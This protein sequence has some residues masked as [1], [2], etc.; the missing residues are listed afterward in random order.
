MPDHNIA[1]QRKQITEFTR[2]TLCKGEKWYILS[3]SW[4]EKWKRYVNYTSTEDDV[5]EGIEDPPGRLDNSDLLANGKLRDSLLEDHDF[6]FVPKTVW[7]AFTEWFGCKHDDSSI[8][9]RIATA[10]GKRLPT[11][12]LKR[13]TFRF[14]NKENDN[15][16]VEQTFSKQDTIADLQNYLHEHL[17]CSADK[18]CLLYTQLSDGKLEQLTDGSIAIDGAS[19]LHEKELYF[20]VVRVL[21]PSKPAA[22]LP[23][24]NFPLTRSSNVGG[25]NIRSGACGLHNLGNTC[26]MNSAIQCIAS[27]QPLTDFF[28]SADWTSEVNVTNPLGARGQIAKAY[29]SLLEQMFRGGDMVVSPRLFKAEVSKYAPQFMGYVQ[30]DAQE[31]MMFLLDG[32]HED[33]NRILNKPYFE[34]KDH[35]GRSD[36]DVAAESWDHFKRRNH[37]IV[38]DHFY[39][40]LKSKVTCREC[41]K[42]SLTFDPY[43]LLSLP[44]PQEELRV[45]HIWPWDASQTPNSVLLRIE[46][47]LLMN[48]QE[49]SLKEKLPPQSGNNYYIETVNSSFLRTYD[50]K[51]ATGCYRPHLFA[52]E[53]QPGLRIMVDFY[54]STGGI[55]NFDLPLYVSVPFSGKSVIISQEKLLMLV[56]DRLRALGCSLSEVAQPEMNGF[57]LADVNT[58]NSSSRLSN[59]DDNGLEKMDDSLRLDDPDGSRQEGSTTRSRSMSRG[60]QLLKEYKLEVTDDVAKCE[61]IP[62]SQGFELRSQGTYIL[63]IFC[64]IAQLKRLITFMK[65]AIGNSET[66]SFKEL[67]NNRT[68][69]LLDCFKLFIKEELLGTRDRWFCPRCTT[70]QP[71]KKKFDL[72]SLPDILVVH[73]KRFRSVYRLDKIEKLVRFP[74]EGLDLTE[75]VAGPTADESYIYNLCAVSNHMGYLGGGHYTAYARNFIDNEWYLFDDS[76]IHRVA[77]SS[78][79]TDAAYVLIYTRV[80]QNHVSSDPWIKNDGFIN[81]KCSIIS[82]NENGDAYETRDSDSNSLN[83]L[84]RSNPNR[85]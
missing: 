56:E 45:V 36:E 20:E 53:L 3:S 71:S 39:G 34:L 43:A 22:R 50:Q 38:V 7:D 57:T 37:S 68:L 6:Q 33:L 74:V 12:E 55:S 59:G 80:K 29:A 24:D 49:D 41:G 30:H 10:V 82:A 21:R 72:W 4:Y 2:V 17:K 66:V 31:L 63:T 27:V 46:T 1:M 85:T 18:E 23:T 40:L 32:L 28:L 15:F 44:L 52:Y 73:L 8:F 77:K 11:I 84:R 83:S 9:E 47:K 61:V 81:S 62:S 48:N 5:T 26:F 51:N 78:L 70:E 60:R 65:V 14:V 58:S 54:C 16:A 69:D 75:L 13:P 79:V 25:E 35:E 19:L 76:H 67:T 42:V 64:T